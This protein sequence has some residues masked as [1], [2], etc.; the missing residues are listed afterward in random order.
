MDAFTS[1][2][3][4]IGDVQ[5]FIGKML[6]GEA[7]ALFEDIRPGLKAISGAQMPNLGMLTA[8]DKVS[9]ELAGAFI[10]SAV[11]VISS[12]PKEIVAIAKD[13]LFRLITFTSPSYPTRTRL[14][15]AEE[16]AFVDLDF[17][18]IY[19]LIGRSFAVNFTGSW[20]ALK[21]R[22]PAAPPSPPPDTKTSTP[23]SPT[24]LTLASAN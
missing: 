10:L 8:G 4:K 6:P 15:Q 13:R 24:P 21:S 19:E 11:D 16:G 17:I 7:F 23:S 20:D 1:R 18:H 5:F 12:L 14:D 3:V 9:P 22:L 2:D